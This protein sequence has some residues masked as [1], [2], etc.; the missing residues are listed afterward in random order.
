MVACVIVAPLFCRQARMSHQ[1]KFPPEAVAAKLGDERLLAIKLVR[2]ANPGMGLREAMD[3]VDAHDPRQ[4][5]FVV[6]PTSTA[7]N[8][9]GLPAEAIAALSRGQVVEAVKIVRDKTG[10]GL[11]ESKDLVDAYRDG[12]V[13]PRDEAMRARL[14][15]I[16]GKH[17]FKVPE[18]AM[19][20]MESGDLKTA[21]QRLRQA[22]DSGLQIAPTG[23]HS[24]HTARAI[25]TVSR[26]TSRNGWVWILLF[27]AAIAAAGFW[28][29]R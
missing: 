20:A 7:T 11:K 10:L 2:E 1:I 17:G 21:L 29:G 22:K 27:A 15:S 19:T 23:L 13:P 24:G 28:F 3:A 25:E 6:G 9:N 14:E 12:E 18:E 4:H 16:A 26:E 8:G 5:G